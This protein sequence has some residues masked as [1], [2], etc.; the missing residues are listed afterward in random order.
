MVLAH[1]WSLIT[2][3]AGVTRAVSVTVRV[4]VVAATAA[5]SA[6]LG[7]ASSASASGAFSVLHIE[8]LLLALTKSDSVDVSV[9]F[10]ILEHDLLHG[11]L[12]GRGRGH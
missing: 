11:R 5:S 7:A 8:G 9:L 12:R 2:S 10:R 6:A 4:V 3:V 1:F